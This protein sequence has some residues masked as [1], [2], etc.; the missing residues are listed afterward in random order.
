MEWGYSGRKGADGLK[1][2]ISKTKEIKKK[3]KGE[4]MS[5]SMDKGGKRHAPAPQREG[6]ETGSYAIIVSQSL[7]N[8][9]SH[10]M[11]FK[12]NCIN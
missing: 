1:K 7:K 12:S 5:K 4:K 11:Q 3:V 6:D 9:G 8:T 2:K 10:V